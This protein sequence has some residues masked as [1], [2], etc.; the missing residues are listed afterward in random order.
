MGDRCNF[1]FRQGKDAPVLYLYGHWAG[2]GMMSQL[3]NALDAAMPRIRMGDSAYSTRIAISHLVGDDWR[4]ETGWGLSIDS[5]CDNEHS[6]P[7]VDFDSGTVSL[8]EAPDW[9]FKGKPDETPI[10]FTMS[11]ESFIAKFAK[12]PIAV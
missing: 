10:K 2:Y 3:A 6:I 4:S 7:I 1:G 8:H 5:L 11:I 12:V 9:G